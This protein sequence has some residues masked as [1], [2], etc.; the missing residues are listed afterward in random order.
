MPI[1]KVGLYY[2]ISAGVGGLL[3]TYAGGLLSDTLAN[4]Y[5]DLR[6]HMRVPLLST[7]GAIP[8]YWFVLLFVDSGSAAAILWTIPAFVGG[9]YMG[10]CLSMTHGM[11]GLRMRSVASAVLFFVLNLIGLGIGPWATGLLSD[12]FRPEYGDHSIRYAMACMALVNIWC[13]AHYHAANTTL[14]EDLA[15]APA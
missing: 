13:A 8:F 7:L 14:R 5:N 3:G 11:V 2:G 6:W 1:E 12:F 10:P 4:R 15:R 9:M